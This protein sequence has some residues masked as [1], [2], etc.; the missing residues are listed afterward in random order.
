MD[1]A[2]WSVDSTDVPRRLTRTVPDSETKL[3]TWIEQ[4]PELV[5]DGLLPVARQ[6]IFPTRERLDLLCI[7]NQS[8]WVIVELKRD[9]MAREA[10]AQ[11]LDYVSLLQQM[12]AAELRERLT[13]HLQRL[14]AADRE[15]AMALLDSETDGTER[16]VAVILAGVTADPALLRITEMLNRT[17]S[18][19]IS[20]VELRAFETPAGDLLL[21]R[22]ETGDADTSSVAQ[23]L[24]RSSPRPGTPEGDR[25]VRV[26]QQAEKYGMSS[27]LRSLRTA[28]EDAGLYPRPYT[29]SVMIT[30]PHQHGRFLAVIGFHGASGRVY[31]GADAFREFYPNVKLRQAE[32]LLG[33]ADV[34]REVDA[35]GLDTFGRG[36]KTLMAAA[37]SSSAP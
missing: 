4:R 20:V 16:E 19:P 22:E 15:L 14:S 9:R 17:Y 35:E 27:A 25:W 8:R 23:S 28:V 11:A 6:L 12:T 29:R 37:S 30:P 26:E 10:V 3:E 2:L 1:F 18:V 13:P 34:D 5:R 33:P 31:W 32:K 24:P 36:L 7:E 21:A